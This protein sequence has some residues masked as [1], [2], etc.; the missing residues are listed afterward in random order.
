MTNRHNPW[1]CCPVFRLFEPFAAHEKNRVLWVW[2]LCV[3]A[4]LYN[5]ISRV[6][7]RT[8]WIGM[9]WFTVGAIIIAAAVFWQRSKEL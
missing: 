7:N 4:L 1:I 8:T 5:P 6:L 2:V 9:N 3:L